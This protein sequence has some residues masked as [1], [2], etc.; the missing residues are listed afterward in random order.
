MQNNNDKLQ[1]D[2]IEG[3]YLVLQ[4]SLNKPIKNIILYLERS[5]AKTVY[6]NFFFFFHFVFP[7][8]KWQGLQ[9]PSQIQSYLS[10]PGGL[11]P[12]LP[13]ITESADAQVPSTK[14][15]SICM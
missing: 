3:Y 9:K 14:W 2:T 6:F 12:E 11:A 10:I 7:N 8:K 5:K 4:E 13:S 1:S 15:R